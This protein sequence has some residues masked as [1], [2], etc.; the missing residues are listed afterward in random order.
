MKPA[1][2]MITRNRAREAAR[3][4]AHVRQCGEADEIVVVDNASRDETT[5]LLAHS[6]PDVRVI[7]LPRNI[8]AA[9]RNIGVEA[10]RA[11][12][13]AFSDDDTIW[14]RGSLTRSVELLAQHATIAVI[15]AHVVVGPEGRQDEF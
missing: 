14:M 15:A 3:T 10:T 4:V 12:Y 1:V 11:K 6:F 8:G 9:A 13:V 7:R 5:E 2:V